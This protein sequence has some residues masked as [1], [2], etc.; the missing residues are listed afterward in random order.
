[1]GVAAV[2]IAANGIELPLAIALVVVGTPVALAAFVRLVPSGT[3]RLAPGVPAAVL[4]RGILTFAFFGTDAYVSL[5]FQ[6]VR[7]QPTWVSGLALTGATIAWTA[8]AWVQERLVHRVG[9]RRLV[10]VGFAC[11][12]VGILGM[13]GAQGAL[14][15]PAAIAVWSVAGFGT[16]LSYSPLSVTVLDLAAPGR[17][18]PAAAGLQLTDVLGTALGTGTGGA[19]VALAEGQGWLTRSALEIA[20]AL[21]LA[22]ALAGLLAARRL[23]AAL[24]T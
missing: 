6:D 10:M 2:L 18:G 23:P 12:A 11:V 5:T 16:G 1:M 3:L 17:E 22:V 15:V 13:L 4:V 21:T 24:P 20:F 14:P 19:L 8:A 7:D 9:P